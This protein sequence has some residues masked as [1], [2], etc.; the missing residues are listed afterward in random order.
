MRSVCLSVC[1]LV[2]LS[3]SVSVCRPV[4]FYACLFMFSWDM[5]TLLVAD[6]MM[7]YINFTNTSDLNY[8]NMRCFHP[9][10]AK[11]KF[12]VCTEHGALGQKDGVRG[13]KNF[14]AAN[15]SDRER[16]WCNPTVSDGSTLLEV[17]KSFK[18]TVIMG[19]TARS[20]VFSEE[21]IRTMASQCEN[22]IIMPMSNPTANAE[23][24]AAEGK[25]EI[26]E[27]GPEK[28]R[29]EENEIVCVYLCV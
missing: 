17:M 7:H 27:R 1:L 8:S 29:G 28:K 9:F 13:D 19:M 4:S 10:Q 16:A 5:C 24:T 20:G 3:L 2:S 22:P 25:R 15:I 14:L 23:C 12:V 11:S 18:P 26:R 21:L 6:T